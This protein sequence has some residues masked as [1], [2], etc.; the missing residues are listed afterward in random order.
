M[1]VSLTGQVALVTGASSGIGA[2]IALALARAGAAVGVNHHADED[3]AERVVSEIVAAGG[4]ARAFAADVSDETGVAELLAAVAREW[5]ALDIVVANAGRQ[6]PAAVG[7]MSLDQWR[8]VVGLD[9]TG[10]FLCGREAIRHFRR[11]GRRGVSRAL[12]KVLFTSSVHSVIPWAGNVNY[13]A[14][15]AGGDMM[16][17]SMAQEV[18]R[19]GIRFNAIAPSTIRSEHNPATQGDAG[20]RQLTLIPYGRF[21]EVEDVARAATWLVS[22]EAD[23]VVGTTLFVDGG[24]T[25]YAVFGEKT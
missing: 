17:R 14:A 5:G 4:R 7:D 3:A 6:D 8:D 25:L 24:M 20:Q 12:G 16:M 15:K 18:A 22:D 10:A 9:L 21:C 1:S 11:Q 19:E 23:F 2:G 13:A